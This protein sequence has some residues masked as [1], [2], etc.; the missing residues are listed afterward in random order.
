MKNS[1]ALSLI[2]VFFACFSSCTG[3]NYKTFRNGF[4]G[5]EGD[6]NPK[7][8]I[9]LVGG[10]YPNATFSQEVADQKAY[11]LSQGYSKE[12]I[13]CYYVPPPTISYDEN[14]NLLK[15]AKELEV[16][17]Q[18]EQLKHS[19]ENCFMASAKSLLR[20]IES[21][22][23]ENP[24]SIYIYITAHGS[25]P[26]KNFSLTQKTSP[27]S[28]L[29]D[30]VKYE[31]NKKKWLKI[32]SLEQWSNT[33]ALQMAAVRKKSFDTYYFMNIIDLAFEFAEEYPYSVNDYLLTPNGLSAALNK[34][35]HSTKKYLV[36]QGCFSGGFILPPQQAPQGNTLQN[37]PNISVL[38]ASS[39]VRTS[40]GCGADDLRTYFGE[41]YFESLKSFNKNKTFDSIDWQ[42][43]HKKNNEKV[44]YKEKELKID[45]KHFSNPQFFSNMKN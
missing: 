7:T 20:H 33:Y 36:L 4:S 15:D 2:V 26:L 9:F 32:L 31:K 19:V 25:P 41:S 42:E 8:R 13:A 3:I 16:S 35:P 29:G 10:G 5:I 43:L 18:F 30:W 27:Q 44:L 17:K 1:Y 22:Q 39:S 6:I 45:S 38:T 12:Q 11:W 28:D 37:V 34:L 40:F 23:K 21:L 24:S 14:G